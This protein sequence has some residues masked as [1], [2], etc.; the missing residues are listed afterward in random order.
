MG[1]L[2]TLKKAGSS[3]YDAL[4]KTLRRLR[5]SRI[6]LI[7]TVTSGCSVKF[8]LAAIK[9]KLPAPCCCRSED[10]PRKMLLKQ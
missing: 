4:Q 1:F 3:T 7:L 2:D 9:R 6:D 5:R 8:V 10:I